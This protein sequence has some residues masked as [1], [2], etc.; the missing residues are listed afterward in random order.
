MV[1]PRRSLRPPI[2]LFEKD[3]LG[4]L[5]ILSIFYLRFS[6]SWA[7]LCEAELA[8]P[9]PTMGYPGIQN[10][11]VGVTTVGKVRAVG[12]DVVLSAT[13]KNPNHATL[14]GLIPK[15]ASELFR[16]T[17]KNPARSRK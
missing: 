13:K 6:R 15:Q 3:A 9:N 17:I 16:P 14:A 5:L 12:R 1:S 7:L 8:A 2:C 11:Q 10:N 4:R